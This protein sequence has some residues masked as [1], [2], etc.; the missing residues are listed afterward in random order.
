MHDFDPRDFTS[1]D[2]DD[3]VLATVGAFGVVSSHD[4]E[5]SFRWAG[6]HRSADLRHLGEKRLN[7]VQVYRA[8]REAAER[9][10]SSGGRL[11]RVV[12]DSE[13]AGTPA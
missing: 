5:A 8:Y 6:D 3:R 1:G 11:R 13:S 10:T 9:L 4:I 2:R 12:L 7:D